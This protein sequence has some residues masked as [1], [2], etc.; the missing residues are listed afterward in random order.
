MAFRPLVGALSLGLLLTASA[1]AQQVDTTPPTDFEPV[2]TAV[3]AP[4]VAT[5]VAPIELKIPTI[6]VDAEI[7]PVGL[8][9]D[10][11][12]EAPKDPD[13]VAWWSLGSGTGEPGNVVLAAH[14]DWGGRLRVFGLLHQLA[15]GDDVVVVDALARELWYQVSWTQQVPADGAPLEEIFGPSGG[16]ELTLITCGGEFDQASH[17]YLSRVIVRAHQV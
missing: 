11:A 4:P 3:A 13:T 14:V 16:H 17:Q 2:P 6:Y 15:P 10:G 7:I 1:S 5:R 8:A 12:M 9:D